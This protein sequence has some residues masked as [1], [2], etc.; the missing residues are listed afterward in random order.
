MA[1]PIA[2]AWSGAVPATAAV[3]Y[4]TPLGDPR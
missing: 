2:I 1:R 4:F 3:P